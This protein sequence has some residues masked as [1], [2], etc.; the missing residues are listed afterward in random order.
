MARKSPARSV[1][2]GGTTS[3]KWPRQLR[4]EGGHGTRGSNLTT[5]GKRGKELSHPKDEGGKGGVEPK[6]GNRKAAILKG[7]CGGQGK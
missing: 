3:T 4:I 5:G 1:W 6:G 2:G 7:N